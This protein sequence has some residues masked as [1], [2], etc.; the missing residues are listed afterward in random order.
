MDFEKLMQQ[1]QQM[2]AQMAKA[3]EELAGETVEASAGGVVVEAHGEQRERGAGDVVGE[4]SLL[5]KD[6]LRRARV[7]A[8]TPVTCLALGRAEFERMLSAEP[9]FAEEMW[10]L[11]REQLA[12]LE[13]SG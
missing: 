4:I 7:V 1:A 11:A 9:G 10:R 6:G 13:D 5:E 3:Q 12:E 2:Q 8:K